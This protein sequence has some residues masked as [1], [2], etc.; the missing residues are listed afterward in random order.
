MVYQSGY[1]ECGKCVVRNLLSMIYKDDSFDTETLQGECRSL[2][3]IR[4]E[5]ERFSLRYTSYE[6]EDISLLK[7]EQYPCVALVRNL[8]VSHF[9]IIEKFSMKK[10][11]IFDP[12]FGKYVLDEKEFADVFMHRMLL[13]DSIGT[14]PRTKK[15]DFLDN[16]EKISYFLCFVF[17]LVCL[18]CFIISTGFDDFFVYSI[19]SFVGLLMMIVLQNAINLM[20]QKRT[21]RDLIHPYMKLSQK[22]EDFALL[23]KV[24]GLNIRRYSNMVS[25]GVLLIGLISLLALNSYLLSFLA[26]IPLFF[27]LARLFLKYDR[28]KSNRYCSFEERLYLNGIRKKDE[29]CYTH[30][31]NARKKG[32]T[33]AVR[34]LF[35]HLF[36]YVLVLV[37]LALE[38]YLIGKMNV[39]LFVYSFCLVTSISAT[40]NRL[41]ELYLD[42]NEEKMK[43]NS[44]SFPLSFFL[45]KTETDLKYNNEVKG[46][47]I[48]NEKKSGSGI[49]QPSE[50]GQFLEETVRPRISSHAEGTEKGYEVSCFTDSRQSDGN[51]TAQQDISRYR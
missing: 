40:M 30:Y 51:P 46:V 1:D 2:L 48:I 16:K 26:L 31:E 15:I 7:K 32:Y 17:Q 41:Y 14:K 35:S 12:Q 29:C 28:N 49:C 39:H 6:V 47:H 3:E 20:V 33:F 18:F 10:I 34:Q 24:I 9:V 19:I 36:E 5:L 50:Q 42:R 22:D 38:L 4:E 8:D 37:L 44:L 23:N 25:Y 43:I 13:L 11:Y 45:F 27:T 21:E